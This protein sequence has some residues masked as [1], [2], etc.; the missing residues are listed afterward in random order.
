MAE[1]KGGVVHA[2]LFA[3]ES[4]RIQPTEHTPGITAG[5]ADKFVGGAEAP[6]IGEEKR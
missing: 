2:D 5:G 1:L 6:V 4:L 3:E